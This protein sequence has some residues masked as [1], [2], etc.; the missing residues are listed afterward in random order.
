MRSEVRDG[1]AEI[2]GWNRRMTSRACR[3]TDEPPLPDRTP[4]TRSPEQSNTWGPDRGHEGPSEVGRGQVLMSVEQHGT[5]EA[6]SLRPPLTSVPTPPS[7]CGAR[8]SPGRQR[9]V[10]AIT[11]PRGERLCTRMPP[12]P[13]SRTVVGPRAHPSHARRLWPPSPSLRARADSQAQDR[14]QKKQRR[15]RNLKETDN[16]K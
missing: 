9:P 15:K 8:L 16:N 13:H 12:A 10:L 3:F 6:G 4:G 2:R 11:G 1:G 7:P 14:G 5:R